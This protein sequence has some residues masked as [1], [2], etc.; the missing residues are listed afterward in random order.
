MK[1]MVLLLL[2]GFSSLSYAQQQLFN[3]GQLITDGRVWDLAFEDLNGDGS[4]DLVIANWLKPPTIFYND[5]NGGFKN[6][7]ALLCSAVEDDSYLG[8]S[9]GIGNLNRDENFDIFYVFNGRNNLL[10][11]GDE[12]EYTK[13][14]TIN[15]KHSYG[16][17]ISLGDIDNDNDI[18][19]FIT[20]YKQANILWIND[21]NGNFTNSYIDF[22]SNG[23]NAE[24]GDINNDGHLDVACSIGG[25]VVVWFNKG[26]NNYEQGAQFIGYPNAFGR[27]KLADIDNDKDMDIILANRSAGGSVWSNDGSGK[28][29]ETTNALTK[30]ST[31]CMGDIDL[32][33]QNDIIFGETI[34]L[35]KGNNKFTPQGS[36]EFEGIILGLWLNDI[37]NDG[38]FDLFY[39]TSVV[40]NGL[41][42]VKNTTKR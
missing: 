24:L 23:Y 37:D 26:N 35:N 34:W 6:S 40:E 27:I 38:D 29:T 10:Y 7:K 41:V 22:G 18:D 11:L 2:F 5:G 31:M 14:D 39:S 4:T 28:F 16:L 9:V 1:R 15:T 25:N 19:A 13:V 33:G 20:N 12:G 30:S 8:H 17:Y 36:L 42:F 21:G 32:D 3:D